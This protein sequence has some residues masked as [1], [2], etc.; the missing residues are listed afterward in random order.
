MS[1][2]L[3]ARRLSSHLGRQCFAMIAIALAGWLSAPVYP[4]IMIWG[5]RLGRAIGDIGLSST[6]PASR[7]VLVMNLCHSA[8]QPL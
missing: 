4:L 5:S 3:S 7:F 6:A 8:A 1:A 2:Q